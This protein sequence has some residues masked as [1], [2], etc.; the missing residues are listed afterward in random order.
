MLFSQHDITHQLLL[1]RVIVPGGDDAFLD[2]RMLSERHFDLPEFYTEASDFDLMIDTSE[3]IEFAVGQVARQVSRFIQTARR[4]RAVRIWNKLL[5]GALR[6]VDITSTDNDSSDIQVT[7]D[8]DRH[9]FQTAVENV[10]A[11]IRQRRADWHAYLVF[12]RYL[13]DDVMRKVV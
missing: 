13:A 2:R 1:S 8:S 3:I 6:V 11:S 7:D 5:C 9:R 10:E 4:L 12:F